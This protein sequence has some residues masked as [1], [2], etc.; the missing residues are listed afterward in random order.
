MPG[1]PLQLLSDTMGLTLKHD[2]PADVSYINQLLLH[3]TVTNSKK[4]I[5]NTD[6]FHLWAHFQL[7]DGLILIVRLR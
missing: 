6:H 7:E 1:L 4:Q 2:T 3:N 5:E